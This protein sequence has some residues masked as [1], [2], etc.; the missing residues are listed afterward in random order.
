MCPRPA[1]FLY[2]LYP[3]LVLWRGSEANTSS[4]LECSLPGLCQDVLLEQSSSASLD[5]CILFGRSTPGAT[6]V[7][8]NRE[9]GACWALQAC[10][11]LDASVPDR[12]SSDVNCTLCSVTG[13]CKG[14]LL[15]DYSAESAEDCLGL[16]GA[17]EGCAW[18]SYDSEAHFCALFQSC[19]DLLVDGHENWM[20][21]EIA[22]LAAPTPSPSTTPTTSA[23]T[24]TSTPAPAEDQEI[25]W[26][27]DDDGA[28]RL[29]KFSKQIFNVIRFVFVNYWFKVINT[30][31]I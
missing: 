23:P 15:I 30:T 16:C 10:D 7:T 22:C 9:L 5:N 6:W 24:T 14:V 31:M 17:E 11:H 12:V 8:F 26:I 13:T 4:S 21:G 3:L 28:V 20:S 19:P 27:N 2:L 18:Y 25:V 1:R 29:G